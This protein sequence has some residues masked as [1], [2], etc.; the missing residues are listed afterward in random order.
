[1]IKIEARK[2]G[3]ACTDVLQSFSF[4]ISKSHRESR[5]NIGIINVGFSVSLWY[6][7]AEK[8]YKPNVLLLQGLCSKVAS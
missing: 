1:M 8:N 3:C 4:I 2:R 6:E 5:E 7:V